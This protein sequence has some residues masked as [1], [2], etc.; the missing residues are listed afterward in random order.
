MAFETFSILLSRELIAA[1]LLFII[2]QK[3]L[4]SLLFKTNT[5]RKLPPGPKGWPILGALPL[6]GSM[7]HVT[8]AKL[9]KQYGPIM[10]LNVGIYGMV[11]ASTPD[12]AKAFLKTLDTNFSNRAPNA[13]A[14]HM[15]YNSG[16]MVFADYGPRWK[17]LRKLSNLHMLGSKALDDWANVRASELAHMLR[18]MRDLSQKGE[19]VVVPQML[20]YA[21]A[22]MIGQVI[23]SRRMF[24][25]VGP[26]SNEFNDM[27]VQLMTIAGYFN[28]GDFL[29]SIAWMDLQGIEGRM[30][31]LHKKFDALL[32]RMLDE[33]MASANE[34]KV[35]PNLLDVIMENR[36]ISEGESLSTA[37]IKGLLLV[38]LAY[39]Y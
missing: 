10:Y 34:H 8:L 4:Q 23:L 13:G 11:I 36:D 35:K 22:N 19:P 15:A 21:I 32:T 28:L 37:N 12:A 29:P 24:A 5:R 20:S 7:P 17:L 26:E 38:G 14:T 6:L 16:D 33:H 31:R 3:I 27:M 30:K 39:T 9:A 2:T 18:E 25:S 1:T